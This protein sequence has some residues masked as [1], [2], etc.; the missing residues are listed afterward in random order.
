MQFDS[1]ATERGGFL[2]AGAEVWGAFSAPHTKGSRPQKIAARPP[3][4]RHKT[5]ALRPKSRRATA[6]RSANA[7]ALPPPAA[8]RP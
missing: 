1:V 7:S 5:A 3:R 2:R 4:R 8:K 6:Q